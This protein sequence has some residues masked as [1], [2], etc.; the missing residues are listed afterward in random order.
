V[1]ALL[2]VIGVTLLGGYLLLHDMERE[3]RMVR[4]R[5]DFVASV[6]H[7]LKTPLTAIRMFAETLRDRESADPELRAD[8]LDTIVGESERL[9]RL[10]NNVLDLSRIEQGQKTYE[11]TPSSLPEITRRAARAVEYPLSLEGFRL[12]MD[13]DEGLPPVTVDADS[14]EQAVLNLL[15]NAMKY[16]GTSRE[17][18]LSLGRQNGHAVISVRD[19]GVGVSTDELPRLTE[20]FYRASSRE[21]DR[22]PGTGLGLTIV[23]HTARAHGG[24]VTAQSQLGEG[25]TFSIHIPL[26]A[27]Q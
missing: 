19:A 21:N 9:T 10:I 23:D 7:E 26:E 3:T 12:S 11:R 17:I 6:S 1:T 24:H 25:S 16:S 4:L 18:D 2:L 14:V 15:T 5:S 22:V 20:K 27:A 8:Y 13:I